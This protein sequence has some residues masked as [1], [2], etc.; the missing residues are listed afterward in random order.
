MRR[1]QIHALA[2]GVVLAAGFGTAPVRAQS[3]DDLQRGVGRISVMDGDVSVRRGD[4]GDWVAGVVNAPLMAGDYIS[5][6]PN[7]RAEVQFDSS[8]LL[9]LGGLGE[10]HLTTL[11]ADRYQL[12]MARG[13]L[14]FNVLRLS[15]ANIEVDTQNVSVRPSKIGVYRISVTDNGESHVT[16]RSGDVEVFTPK[17][18]QWVNAGQAMVARGSASD[19]EFRIAGAAALDDWDRWN[20]SRDHV[21]MESTSAQ[22]VPQGVYGAEDMD[23]YGT[24]VNVP[25]YGSVWRPTVVAGWSPYSCGRW[26]WEDW[27]GWTWVDCSAWG[28][29]PFHYGR[30]FWGA[31]Y[32]WLWYPGVIGVRHYWAPG[33]VA[34]FG[35][36]GGGFG[37]GFGFGNLGWVPLAPYEMFHPWWGHSY[38]GAGFNRGFNIGSANIYSNYRNARIA[39][40][41]S[42]LS[43]ADFRGGRFNSVGHASVDQIRSAGLIRGQVPLSPTS[44]NLRYS[45]RTST[46]TPR[47]TASQSFFTHQNPASVTRVP[48]ARQAG[49]STVAASGRTGEAG[50]ARR[51]ANGG[52]GVGASSAGGWR[53]FG[54]PSGQGANSLRSAP[55]GAGNDRPGGNSAGYRVAPPVVRERSSGGNASSGPE[56]RYSRP[57]YSEPQRSSSP[58]YSTSQPHY[59]SSGESAP[60]SSGGTS[61]SGGHVSSGGGGAHA[62]GGHGGGRR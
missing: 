10:I 17:G 36:G 62:S 52:E 28:W 43:V 58:G 5:T 2:F 8:N 57:S 55:S 21:L 4:S 15:N 34:F 40:G 41:V 12:E 53:R 35:F 11:E 31:N 50:A 45:E 16:V 3:S 38:Y 6:G 23:G 48:F 13:T 18:S 26:V 47:S 39:N 59:G 42:S 1:L 22:H 37:V 54:E 14:T 19:P 7:S 20:E 61:G 25:D 56:T 51:A 46:F 32:G 24:W 30:W 33:L 60:R 9:R 29:A 44:A 27:Y 49:G